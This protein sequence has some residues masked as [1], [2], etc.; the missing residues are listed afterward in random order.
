MGNNPILYSDFLGDTSIFWNAAGAQIHR[1]DDGSKTNS[2]TIIPEDRQKSFDIIVGAG[3]A[4][5][6]YY[7]DDKGNLIDY[8]CSEIS[9]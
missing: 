8:I 2:Y 7:T 5:K 6:A 9:V 3:D 1:V 4:V